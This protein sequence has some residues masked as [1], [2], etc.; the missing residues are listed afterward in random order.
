MRAAIKSEIATLGT[1]PPAGSPARPPSF[2][3]NE[4]KFV[5]EISRGKIAGDLPWTH[6]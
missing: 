5:N 4:A 3:Q 6:Q 1:A 2:W